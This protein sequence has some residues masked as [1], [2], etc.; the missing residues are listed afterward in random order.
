MADITA[1]IYWKEGRRKLREIAIFNRSAAAI[2]TLAFSVFLLFALGVLISVNL[3]TLRERFAWTQHTEEVLQQLTGVQQNLVRMESNLRAYALTQ[4]RRHVVIWPTLT[5]DTRTRLTKLGA[6]ISDDPGQTQRLSALRPR[7]EDRIIRWSRIVDMG[8]QNNSATIMRDIQ[9]Q[10]ARDVVDRPLRNIGS[11]LSAFRA[12]ETQLLQERQKLAERQTVL[13]TYLSFMIVLAA[14]ALG[15][16]GL[17]LLLREQNR[18]RNRE[19]QLQLEHSQRLNLMG[20]TASTLAHELKQ[21]LTSA[22]NYLAVLKNLCTRSGDE[23]A[24][25][26][27]QKTGDQLV[28][29]NAI[30]Q[31]LRNFIENRSGERHPERPE[32]LVADAIALL[33][34]LDMRYRLQTEIDSGLPEILV[35]RVQ[36]QQVLVNLMRNAVEAMENSMRKELSLS[37]GRIKQDMIEFRLR[38]SGPGL[39]GKIRE[40]VFEPFNSSKQDGMGV[41]LSICKRIIQD[42]SGRI[43]VEDA[44]DGGTIFCFTLPLGSP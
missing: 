44:P 30:I 10:L 23:Q 9:N 6:L 24:L 31:R 20:E 21:P 40:R 33:G 2:G 18:L 8:L 35:D 34:I 26:V 13:L 14:P 25:G 32:T 7:I 36:I 37:V 5:R 39:P 22:T 16:I 43:W 38:D 42:H 41:G 28:R 17:V 3:A 4:D 11:G 29:A 12:V 1:P 19:L 27:A 15:A